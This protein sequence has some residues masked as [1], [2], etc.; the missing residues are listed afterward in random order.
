VQREAI[1]RCVYSFE[2]LGEKNLLANIVTGGGKT[3]IELPEEQFFLQ[4]EGSGSSEA[5]LERLDRVHYP[6]P[7]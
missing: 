1:E 7:S 4:E 6:G 5:E 3:T 2:I